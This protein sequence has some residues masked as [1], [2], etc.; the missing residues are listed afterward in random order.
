MTCWSQQ[1]PPCPGAA[2]RLPQAK[3][4]KKKG[5]PRWERQR[6]EEGALSPP[7][8]QGNTETHGALRGRWTPDTAQPQGDSAEPGDTC[9][10]TQLSPRAKRPCVTSCRCPVPPWFSP[11]FIPPH[12]A[13]PPCTNLPSSTSWH[14]SGPSA[15][16]RRQPPQLCLLAEAELCQPHLHCQGNGENQLK[17]LGFSVLV[18]C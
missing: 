18:L 14:G 13:P 5:A 15:G 4:K 10:G 3:G 6:G 16:V 7:C 12:S 17:C 8:G 11:S 2:L 9:A 1:G